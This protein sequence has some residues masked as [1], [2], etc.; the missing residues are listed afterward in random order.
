MKS[1][2]SLLKLADMKFEFTN[3]EIRFHKRQVSFIVRLFF[4]LFWYNITTQD[5]KLHNN[6]C[7][8]KSK[9]VNVLSTWSSTLHQD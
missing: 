7:I 8:F 6:A 9:T 1:I 2:Q 3:L 5:Q 4:L